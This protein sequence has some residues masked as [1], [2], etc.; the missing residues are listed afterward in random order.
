M[1]KKLYE[2]K[3]FSTILSV[4]MYSVRRRVYV[5]QLLSPQFSKLLICSIV[6]SRS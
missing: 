3:Y 2:V 6:L 1:V 5:V 4:V